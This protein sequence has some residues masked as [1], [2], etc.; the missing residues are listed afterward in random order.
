MAAIHEAWDRLETWARKN[1]PDLLEYLN[2][3]ATED[4]LADLQQRLGRELPGDVIDSLRR[5]NGERDLRGALFV[6]MGAW[7]SCEDILRIRQLLIDAARQHEEIGE[8]EARRLIADQIMSVDGHVRPLSFHPDW[9]PVLYM[10][11]RVLWMLDFAPPDGGTP[12]Q[13]IRV[14]VECLDWQ[15]VAPGFAA[16]LNGYVDAL[17]TNDLC[18]SQGAAF[19]LAASHSPGDQER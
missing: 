14:D 8:D 15:V 10:N 7:L 13:V 9:V 12:G 2:A 18:F 19:K 4:E 5:Y 1:D 3:G 11:G 6:D 17:E 16:F